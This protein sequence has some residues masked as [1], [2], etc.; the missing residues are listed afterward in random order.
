LAYIAGILYGHLLVEEPRPS[1]TRFWANDDALRL[2]RGLRLALEQ[3]KTQ[4]PAP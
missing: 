4:S 2:V 3:T 1:F